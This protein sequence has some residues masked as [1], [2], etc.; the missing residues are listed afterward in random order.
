[1]AQLAGVNKTVVGNCTLNLNST[2]SDKKIS[3]RNPPPPVLHIVQG[4]FL[5]LI[6]SCLWRVCWEIQGDGRFPVC[7]GVGALA[8]HKKKKPVAVTSPPA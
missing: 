5:E 1:M 2:I 6:L 8:S 3:P 4:L 7:E